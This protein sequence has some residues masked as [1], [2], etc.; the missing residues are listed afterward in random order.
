MF[1]LLKCEKV[2]RSCRTL[3]QLAVAR[4]YVELARRELNWGEVVY[5]EGVL[6]AVESEL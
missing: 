6:R 1:L 2:I 4:R 5:I 3:A